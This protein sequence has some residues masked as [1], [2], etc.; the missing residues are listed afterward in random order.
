MRATK[1]VAGCTLR[2][3]N[4]IYDVRVK[5]GT[6]GKEKRAPAGGIKAM[7]T[8]ARSSRTGRMTMRRK[9]RKDEHGCEPHSLH[10]SSHTALRTPRRLRCPGC[11]SP[12][13]RRR[14][15]KPRACR[16]TRGWR[17]AVLHDH[18]LAALIRHR[19]WIFRLADWA[20]YRRDLYEE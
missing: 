17:R 13:G 9:C 20:P 19:E 7:V 15:R 8:G 14:G 2:Y 11:S 10:T 16:T 1:R 18:A 3:G 12:A 4:N 5:K 6:G